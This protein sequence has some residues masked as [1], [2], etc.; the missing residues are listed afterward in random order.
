MAAG[1]FLESEPRSGDGKVESTVGRVG[2]PVLGFKAR[3]TPKMSEPLEVLEAR[4]LL[5]GYSN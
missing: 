5:C 2:S 1:V 4:S 3:N